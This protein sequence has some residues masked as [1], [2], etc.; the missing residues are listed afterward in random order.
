MADF[1][2][3]SVNSSLAVIN[4]AFATL[5]FNDNFL[6]SKN[7]YGITD[8]TLNLL[9]DTTDTVSIFSNNGIANTYEFNYV[10]LNR[11]NVTLPNVDTNNHLVEGLSQNK[12]LVFVD[13]KLQPTSNYTVVDENTLKFNINYTNDYNKLYS[14]IV[15]SSSSNF[16]RITYSKNQFLPLTEDLRQNR[17]TLPLKYEYKNTLLFINEH[18]VPFNAIE[19][20]NR[21]STQVQLN[22]PESFISDIDSF[23][24]IKF[25]D[26]NTSSI[27]FTTR[28]GYLTYGPYDDFGNKLANNYDILFKFTDQVKLLIDN[29][30][31]GF[32]IKETNG[33]GEAIIVDTNFESYEAKALMVQPFPKSSYTSSEYYVMV[34][35]YT[36]ILK[37]L[38]EFDKQYSFLPEILQ[39]FQ[40]LLLDEINDTIQRLRKARSISKVDSIHINKLIS[41]LGFDINIKQLNKKQRRE[42]L[43]E[44]NEFYRIAGTRSSYNLINVLQNNLKLISADQLFTPSGLSKRKN[45][46]L[47]TYNIDIKEPGDGYAVN[48]VLALETSGLIAKITEIN[49]TDP[50]ANTGSISGIELETTEGYKEINQDF[51]MES[52]LNGTF[53]VN[54]TPNLYSYAWTVDEQQNCINGTILESS[55]K[56]YKIQ[57]EQV[58]GDVVTRFKTLKAPHKYDVDKIRVDFNKLQLY[59]LIDNINATVTFTP[60]YRSDENYGNAIYIDNAGGHDFSFYLEPGTYFV[61]ASGGGGA[62]GAADSTSGNYFDWPARAG[63]NGEYKTG[64]FTLNEGSMIYGKV[65][66]GGGRVKA[67]GHDP[68]PYNEVLGNGFENGEL[69]G[70]LHYSEGNMAGGQGGGSTGLRNAKGEVLF[71][72]RGGNGGQAGDEVENILKGIAPG[73][74]GGGGGVTSGS[75]AAGGD[76]NR[77]ETFWSNNGA[78]GWIEIYRLDLTYDVKLNGDLSGVGNNEVW[79]TVESSPKFTITTHKVDDVVTYEF[80]P[81]IGKLGCIGTFSLESAT[82][83]ASAKLSIASTVSLWDYTVQL[84]ADASHI[85]EGSTFIN[86][87]SVPEEQFVFTTSADHS[88]EGTWVPTQGINKIIL[89]GV[90]A[91]TRQGEGASVTISSSIDDQKNEDRCYID[92]YKKE[93]LFDKS[94]G[95]GIVVEFREDKIEYGEVTIGTPNSPK[96]WEVGEPDIIY[97]TISDSVSDTINYGTISETAEGEWVEYWKWDR[98]KNWYPTN[99]VDLEMKLPPGVN[100]SEYVDTFV[101][102][103]YNLA[104]TVVF[105]HQITESF[106]FG[107]DTATS[108]NTTVTTGEDILGDPGVMAAPFGIVSTAPFTEH[109]LIVTSD[110]KFQYIDPLGYDF[111][112]T[113]I[114]MVPNATVSVIVE[115][116]DSQGEIIQ[117]IIPLTEQEDWTTKIQYGT[118]ISYKVEAPGYI[119]KSAAITVDTH[120]VK[121][122]I[123]ESTTP[124]EPKYC[125]LTLIT[126][127]L[128]ANVTLTTCGVTTTNSHSICA[129]EGNTI[130]Y[131]VEYPGYISQSDSLVITDNTELEITLERES[132]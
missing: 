29:I 58:A 25:T 81:T 94:K 9:V 64:Y 99:H 13:G 114:P 97:G 72:A 66:Q 108:Y 117:T 15:Y 85:S 74:L 19:V 10:R 46:T 33:Y 67:R 87:D 4:T 21:E 125:R 73:G 17:F 98:D 54:S 65:G 115:N 7:K 91:Y 78:D 126:S 28:Q 41:L 75:G 92:F 3:I 36:S 77:T 121:H 45:S 122:V 53:K 109:E 27:N 8:N 23:E 68:K 57:V 14:V 79:E 50:E 105:I 112:V 31:P 82:E 1:N 131:T 90:K 5:C 118:T 38:A 83:K 18:K 120:I 116:V 84:N 127:P 123:L 130:F 34:P 49:V 88:T 32:I 52:V 62:G 71:R 35:E 39:V 12:V 20:L 59:R 129:W 55:E 2:Q 70:M 103:F 107:N 43:E 16:Q 113:I 6:I 61:K 42:L 128:N 40:R 95:E 132:N 76:R 69:G 104:S 111:N 80:S 60:I 96:P 37:Y 11:P 102:Q 48:D 106:Y 86:L 100:F 24:I 93:E 101:E 119:T 47:Y 124:V 51:T 63:S 89:D 26:G 56:T 30:R 44:L 110:P 22:I